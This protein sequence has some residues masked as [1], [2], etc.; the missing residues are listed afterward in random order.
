[1]Q[2]HSQHCSVIPA[3]PPRPI[4]ASVI[5]FNQSS[6]FQAIEPSVREAKQEMLAVEFI[7][8]ISLETCS[9]LTQIFEMVIHRKP[10]PQACYKPAGYLSRFFSGES[11]REWFESKTALGRVVAA[12]EDYI[13]VYPRFRERV[14][15][16][17]DFN[18]VHEAVAQA[19]QILTAIDRELTFPVVEAKTRLSA[20]FCN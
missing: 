13:T 16:R 14:L 8:K 19:A 3:C 15:A 9:P 18:L 6:P 17:F 1:M 20:P 10:L 2:I 12:F 7:Q 4:M 11:W 5:T